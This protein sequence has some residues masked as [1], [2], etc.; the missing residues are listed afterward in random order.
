M[1][2]SLLPHE[3]TDGNSGRQ[4]EQNRSEDVK[5]PRGAQ[6]SRTT[7]TAGELA[8]RGLSGNMRHDKLRDGRRQSYG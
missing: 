5:L 3:G 1:R 7:G 8:E 4:T 6:K 2:Y